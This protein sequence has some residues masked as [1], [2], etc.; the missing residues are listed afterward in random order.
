MAKRKKSPVNLYREAVDTLVKNPQTKLSIDGTS[1][2]RWWNGLFWYWDGKHYVPK[3][4][5]EFEDFIGRLMDKFPPPGIEQINRNTIAE[6]VACF[7][8]TCRVPNRVPLNTHL[9]PQRADLRDHYLISIANGILDVTALLA[10][11]GPVELI[12]HSPWWFS[13]VYFPYDYDPAATCPVWGRLLGEWMRDNE[14]CARLLQEFFGLC[15]IPDNTR[16]VIMIWEGSGANGKSVAAS[17][18]H[19]L[20]GGKDNVSGVSL[21]MLSVRF[22]SYQTLGKLLNISA[23]V[24][25]LDKADEKLLKALTGNDP[26]VFETKFCPPFTA[27]GTAR[28]LIHT[29]TKPHFHDRTEALWR[30]VTVVPWLLVVPQDDWDTSLKEPTSRKWPF[31]AE[32]SGIFNWALT[33]Y[34]RLVRNNKLTKPLLCE[35]AKTQYRKDSSSAL[36]FLVDHFTPQDTPLKAML[37]YQEYRD[38]CESGGYQPL[39]IQNFTGMVPIVFPQAEHTRGLASKW[40]KGRPHVWTG[41]FRSDPR[42]SAGND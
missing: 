34:R 9:D 30:R 41:L 42:F 22:Q 6:V 37:L 39:S 23:D 4:K 5:V 13:T 36:L 18:L 12:P 19:E 16:E 21:E 24:P 10:S 35:V 32:M 1:T 40:G 29:N 38:F 33:G 17:V 3:D 31:W 7:R 8:R 2:I 28:L 26:V 14:Q 20:L 25:E 15:L 11:A 27:R